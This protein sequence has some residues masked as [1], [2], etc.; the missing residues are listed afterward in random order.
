[1]WCHQN[2]DYNNQTVLHWNNEAYQEIWSLRTLSWTCSSEVVIVCI[3]ITHSYLLLAIP[4]TQGNQIIDHPSLVH[5]STTEQ[6]ERETRDLQTSSLIYIWK[7]PDVRTEGG[8]LCLFFGI[9]RTFEPFIPSPPYPIKRNRKWWIGEGVIQARGKVL[10]L[11]K[12]LY[13]S[14]GR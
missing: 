6:V 2:T 5:K 1:M 14:R 7:Y 8:R 12:N 9:R 3:P 10:I 4:A 13:L 11:R